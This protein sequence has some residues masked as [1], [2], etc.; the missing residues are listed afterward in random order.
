MTAN[1]ETGVIFPIKEIAEISRR[2]GVLFHTDAVQTPGK[3]ALDVRDTGVDF[4]SL[5]GHKL[6][7]PKGV[8]ILY[9]KRRTKHLPFVIGGG[10]ERGKRGGT[11]NVASIVGLG[12]AAQLSLEHLK[13]E[14]GRV[15]GLRD[16]L[17][18]GI[19]SSIANVTI[20][21]D[22]ESRLPN[23]T[24]ISFNGVESEALLLKLD[25]YNICV[26]AGSACTTGALEPSHVLTAMGLSADA[27]HSAIRFSLSRYNSDRDIEK[28]LEV[29]PTIVNQLRASAP[30]K[31][32]VAA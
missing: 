8:G 12:Q 25:Q 30:V 19:V 5:S 23:T 20:N 16:K 7:A 22:T 4:L 32:E 13:E 10:Q 3:I 28:T 17:E 1:N 29:L 31:S 6:H 2:K 21:G 15:R 14:Q 18:K 26:S 9:V 11:E 24:N 27:A